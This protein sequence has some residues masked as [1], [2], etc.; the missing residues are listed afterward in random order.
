ML[1]GSKVS[2]LNAFK[3]T[4]IGLLDYVVMSSGNYN[5]PSM[6]KTGL[7]YLTTQPSKKHDIKPSETYS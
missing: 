6:C 4:D 5:T 1:L 7:E 3:L 2:C